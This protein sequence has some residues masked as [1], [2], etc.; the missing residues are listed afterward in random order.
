MQL[1]IVWLKSLSKQYRNIAFT[2]L[3]IEFTRSIKYDSL[4]E[5]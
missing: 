4:S 1:I 5:Q 3:Y 2:L